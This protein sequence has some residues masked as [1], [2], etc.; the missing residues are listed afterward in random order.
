MIFIVFFIISEPVRNITVLCH[1]FA[2]VR[3]PVSSHHIFYLWSSY[4]VGSLHSGSII[5]YQ[6]LQF[7]FGCSVWLGESRLRDKSHT[8]DPH[9][10]LAGNCARVLQQNNNKNL[11]KWHIGIKCSHGYQDLLGMACQFLVYLVFW[12]W[13]LYL[14][15]CNHF[16][17][18]MEHRNLLDMCTSPN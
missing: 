9:V 10:K 7:N 3:M 4:L 18:E 11:R 1:N 2:V 15:Q 12:L 17:L 8:I 5:L 14:T 16:D 6:M 13:L